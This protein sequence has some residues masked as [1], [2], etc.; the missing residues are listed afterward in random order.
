MGRS[1]YKKKGI[2]YYEKTGYSKSDAEIR[3]ENAALARGVGSLAFIALAIFC[4]FLLV[5]FVMY[6]FGQ[7]LN[8]VHSIN[9]PSNLTQPYK[10][11]AYYCNYL[12]F[13][14]FSI[15]GYFWNVTVTNGLTK[16][17][18]FNYII[19]FSVLVLLPAG[20]V[21]AF[22]RLEEHIQARVVVAAVALVAIPVVILIGY[23]IFLLFAVIL[24]WLF[25]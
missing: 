8:L 23:W 21:Y 7:M 18:N 16:F 24:G 13:K 9:D 12:F 10:F 15:I 17:H 20:C 19:F 1:Y 25:A 4:V 14:P 3:S 2:G 22:K 6:L 5:L 11:L